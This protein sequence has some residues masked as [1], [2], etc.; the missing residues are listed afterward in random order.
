MDNSTFNENRLRFARKRRGLTIKKLGSLVD[1]TPK[2]ISDYENGKHTPPPKTI[3]RLAKVLNFPESFFQLDDI[4]DL[5]KSAV[6]FRSFSKMTACVRDSALSIGKIAIEFSSWIEKRFALPQVNIPDLRDYEPEAAAITLRNIWAIGELSISNMIHLL[7]SKGVRVFSL[8]EKLPDMDAYSFWMDKTPFVFVNNRK[9][10]ERG[11]FDAAHE[12]GHLVLH[13]HGAPLSKEVEI[14]AN[15]FASAFLMPRGSVTAKAPRFPSLDIF[16]GLKSHWCV[17]ASAL[18]K[19]MSDLDLI[20]KWHYRG[21][22]IELSSKWGRKNEPRPIKQRETSSLLPMIFRELKKEGVSK[23]EVARELRIFTPDLDSILFYLTL[24]GV[25]GGGARH[26]NDKAK[27]HLK[28][29]K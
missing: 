19:R 28:L 29:I 16:L 22:M 2:I 13:K 27:T 1:M 8:G 25:H 23:D 4:A 20:S 12:L 11:R 3:S 18:I 17:S 14:E 15:R 5:D 7:E 21:L 26:L 24:I 9:T 10:V 6:S